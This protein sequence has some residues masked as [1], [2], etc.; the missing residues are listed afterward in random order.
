MGLLD[1]QTV[2]LHRNTANRN[3]DAKFKM[4]IMVVHQ[5][6]FFHFMVNGRGERRGFVFNNAKIF[7]TD[8]QGEFIAVKARYHGVFRQAQFNLLGNFLNNV[9]AEPI[10]ITFINS[11][12][13]QDINQQH[14]NF[15]TGKFFGQPVVKNLIEI[16]FV[17]QPCQVIKIVIFTDFVG[18]FPVRHIVGHDKG[19]GRNLIFLRGILNKGRDDAA[20][21]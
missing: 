20:Y 13:F 4:D 18:E 8:Q 5:D 17:G 7:V 3:P 10:A 14:R 12:K 19:Q 16:I 11:L 2:I 21:D 6:R 9:I 1:Q 15:A